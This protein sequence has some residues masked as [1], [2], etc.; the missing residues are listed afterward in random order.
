MIQGSFSANIQRTITRVHKLDYAELFFLRRRITFAIIFAVLCITTIIV[1]LWFLQIYKGYEFEERAKDNRVREVRI[2]APRGNILDRQGKLLIT[3]RPSFNVMWTKEDSPDPDAIIKKLS[4]IFGDDISLILERIRAGEDNP[5][6]MRILLKEDIDWR[7]L[8]YLENN[9]FNLPGIRIKV[10]PVREYLQGDLASHIIGYL[11]Q[12]SREELRQ[13]RPG[14]Y[15]GGDHIGKQGLEKIFEKHLRGEL[16]LSML[17][18]DVHGFEKN[19]LATRQPLPGNDIKLTIDSDLQLTAEKAL[20]GKAGAI[21]ASEVNSGRI[22][23][24]ASSPPLKLEQFVG[25]IS[26]KEWQAMLEDP[27]HPLTNKTIQGQYPPASTY[28]IITALAGLGEEAI[29]PKTIYYCTGALPFGNRTFRCWKRAGH[30]PVNLNRAL[31]ESCDVYFYH[32]SQELHVD[33]LAAYAENLGFGKKTGINLEHEKSGLVPTSDWKV[34]KYQEPWQEGETLA[35]SIGQGFNLA[36]PLQVNMMMAAIANGGIVYRPQF[37]E[38]IID[39]DGKI[40]EAFSPIRNSE[41]QGSE[42][43]LEIIRTALIDAV[44]SPG[45]T[46]SQ[47]ALK[48]IKVAGKTGTAQVVHLSQVKDLEEHEIPYKYR[49]HAWFTCYV[50]AEQPEIAI[51]VLVEHG[52]HG[53]STAGPIAR[54]IM[55]RYFKLDED[56]D[57]PTGTSP[58]P[59]AAISGDR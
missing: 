25:G 56:T 45:G 14:E 2:T 37:V 31:A 40:I 16:G 35:V 6:Y 47:A 55:M 1:R 30:G 50:P 12:I 39:P 24:L 32:L 13:K 11:S 44:S 21:I 22:L 58:E 46:G 34:D 42:E 41:F 48:N 8:V 20:E 26:S 43:N 5:K 52:S 49:D 23:V 53:G 19:N 38:E 27:L 17:E 29:N 3:N 33:T 54:K 57:N 59:V 9:H 7:T 10:I 15:E 28:K 51:T 4:K 18:V 36:T